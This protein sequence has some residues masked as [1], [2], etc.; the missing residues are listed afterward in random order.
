MVA[1]STPRANPND[2]VD[3]QCTLVYARP[4]AYRIYVLG[5]KACLLCH[6]LCPKA[7]LLTR[8]LETVR[9]SSGQ[10]RNRQ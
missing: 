7:S 9:G 3:I 10:R 1:I 6:R 5:S 8:H 4:A 2:A